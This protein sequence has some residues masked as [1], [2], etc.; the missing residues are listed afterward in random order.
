R[1][2]LS[3]AAPLPRQV[4]GE[5]RALQDVP[6]ITFYGLTETAFAGTATPWS[7]PEKRGTAGLPLPGTDLKIVDP[8]TG[9]RTLPAGEAGEVCLKGPQ[10]MKGYCKAPGEAGAAIREGWLFTGDA[11][12]LDGEGCLTVLDRKADRIVTDGQAFYPAEIDEVLLT[13]PAVLEA[14]TIGIPDAQRGQAVKAYV[15]LRPGETAEGQEIMAHCKAR[16][17]PGKVL[18]GV[19]LIHE[20]PKS[21]AGKILRR[22]VRELDKKNQAGKK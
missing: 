21:A 12:F 9:T 10:V 5:L 16:L 20:L 2:F 4:I 13:H 6:V 18:H 22:E 15:V 11:G 1:A 17:A 14:C 8:E 19:V 3:G 7:G